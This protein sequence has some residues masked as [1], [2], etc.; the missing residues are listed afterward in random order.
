MWPWPNCSAAGGKGE[1]SH[2]NRQAGGRRILVNR[3]KLHDCTQPHLSIGNINFK[4][5]RV[6]LFHSDI[7]NSYRLAKTRPTGARF[8]LAASH[9]NQHFPGNHFNDKS[10]SGYQEPQAAGRV[11]GDVFYGA[12][13]RAWIVRDQ[14]LWRFGAVRLHYRTSGAFFTGASEIDQAE[15]QRSLL[16]QR[17]H[18]PHQRRSVPGGL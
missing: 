8:L 7:M 1:S 13:C 5:W 16:L 14:A 6:Y 18:Q 9:P 2:G 11:G 3:Q 17:D 10:R 12:S 15:A 4:T